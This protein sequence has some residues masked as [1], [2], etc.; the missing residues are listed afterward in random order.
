MGVRVKMRCF[1]AETGR[2][3]T[4]MFAACIILLPAATQ[5]AVISVR[6]FGALY[7]C[8][9]QILLIVKTTI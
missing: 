6:E 4:K 9:V 7:S 5:T 3:Q 8:L 2:K 1:A